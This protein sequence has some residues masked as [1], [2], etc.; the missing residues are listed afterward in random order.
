VRA[1]TAATVSAALSSAALL[2]PTL[3]HTSPPQGLAS[4]R[5]AAP[6]LYS[7]ALRLLPA[8]ARQWFGDLRR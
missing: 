7:A 8:S 1:A 4:A 2:A 3:L 5:A 6:L